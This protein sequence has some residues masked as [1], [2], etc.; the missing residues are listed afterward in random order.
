MLTSILNFF[1]KYALSVIN[2]AKHFL[3]CNLNFSLSYLYINVL[4]TFYFAWRKED[5]VWGS[6]SSVVSDIRLPLLNQEFKV[7]VLRFTGK[8][9]PK[10][11]WSQKSFKESMTHKNVIYN[12]NW[13]KFLK[14]D[15]VT[16]IKG[17]FHL[18]LFNNRFS[19]M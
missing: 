4:K 2:V 18:S 11:S 9:H 7:S 6:Y 8:F 3:A 10:P 15:E 5:C 1:K 19:V 17:F 16:Y 13:K 12:Y 14:K